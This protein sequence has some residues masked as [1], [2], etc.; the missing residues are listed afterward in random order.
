MSNLIITIS[1]EFASG[2]RIIGEKLAAGLGVA[3]YDKT[4]IEMASEKSGLSPEFIEQSEE[5]ASNSFL[6]NLATTAHSSSSF[7]LQYD[8]PVNDKAFFAQAS[9]IRELASR[10]SCVIVG[11]CADHILRE[12][13]NLVKV[14]IHGNMEDR[15]KNAINYGVPLQGVEDKI[16]K[17]DKS[18]ANY[19]KYYTGE[20]WGSVKNFDLAINTSFTGTN[21]AV[22][23][24]MTML[25][26]KGLI[27]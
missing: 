21:G 15:I 17:I 10:D 20:P 9:V 7:V 5:K 4:I 12:Q 18:R 1:R 13:P 26:E 27:K 14:F 24:I 23:V 6:F 16:K 2:G 25:R 22:A 8:T 19:Y 3:F 11:R